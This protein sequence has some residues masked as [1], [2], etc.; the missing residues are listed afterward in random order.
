MGI[1]RGGVGRSQLPEGFWEGDGRVLGGRGTR[2]TVKVRPKTGRAFL[3]CAF[4]G[5]VLLTSILFAVG[6]LRV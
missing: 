4:L 6:L 2:S 5:E 1:Y 3:L